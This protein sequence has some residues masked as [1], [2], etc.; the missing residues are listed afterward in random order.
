[1][2]DGISTS[3]GY[4]ESGRIRVLGVAGPRR[5]PVL[6]DLPTIAES[7]LPGF[8][9]TVWFGLFAPAGIAPTAV[10]KVNLAMNAVLA[11]TPVRESFAKLGI[12]PAG[13]GAE[14]LAAR[15]QAEMGK[16]A[17]LV[18]VKNIHLDR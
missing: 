9:T 11:S 7:A 3:L 17:D 6:P 8:D 16:W 1:M 15:V 14:V 10:H 5:T 18:R 13:G 4:I 2:L 12:E